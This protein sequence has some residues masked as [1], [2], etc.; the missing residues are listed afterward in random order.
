MKRAEFIQEAKLLIQLAIPIFLAQIALTSL[1]VVDTLMS[2]WVGTHDLAAIGLGSSILLPIF[3]VPT[4]ILLALTPLIAKSYGKQ[5]HL[6][7]RLFLIQGLWVALPLGA[8]AALVLLNLKPLLLSLSLE[9]EVFRL[10]LD[11]LTYIAW[12]LPGIALFQALRFFWEGLGKTLPTMLISFFALL[13]NIPLNAI[14]IY[15]LGPIEAQGAAGCGIASSLVMWSMFLVGLGYVL[16]GFETRQYLNKLLEKPNFSAIK[17]ILTLGIPNT[18]ALLF[19][20]SLFSLIALFIAQLG[21][22]VIAAHQIALSYSS[23]VF[24]VPLSLSMAVSVRIATV[25]GQN[26]KV[27]LLSVY[28]VSMAIALAVGLIL[29]SFT[30]LLNQTIVGWFTSDAAVSQLALILLF[31]A[32]AYQVF[33]SI[34]STSAGALRGLHNTKITMVVTFVSYWLIGLGMGYV[35]S[36]TDILVPAMGVEGFWLGIFIGIFFAA[37]ILTFQLRQLMKRTVL[38]MAS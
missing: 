5:D 15:G 36:L 1:G 7:I 14:F 18:L 20:V 21:S 33:D 34:Q 8:I 24:M 13:I 23:L 30:Y 35:L 12:G 10:T 32:I 17:S 2:S 29:M 4:G 9:P 19:E 37:V 22:V 27:R 26:N 11:Y 25:Y 6:Q 31:Y 3:M 28:K 16:S 38:E